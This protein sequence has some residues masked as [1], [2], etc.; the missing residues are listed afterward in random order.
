MV[1]KQRDIKRIKWAGKGGKQ[2]WMNN[3]KRWLGEEGRKKEVYGQK[4]QG[5]GEKGSG[6]YFHLSTALKAINTYKASALGPLG[7]CWSMC[8]FVCDGWLFTLMWFV[9][10]VLTVS[11][12]WLNL[13]LGEKLQT[14][15]YQC[16][17]CHCNIG[18][19][20]TSF[21]WQC[22]RTADT[23][24]VLERLQSRAPT[25]LLRGQR[26]SI[27]K[28]QYISKQFQM[29]Q[30]HAR[31]L[32]NICPCKNPSTWHFYEPTKYVNSCKPSCSY[33]LFYEG[34]MRMLP[35]V[36]VV[37]FRLDFWGYNYVRFPMQRSNSTTL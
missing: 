3:G 22:G 25:C 10:G 16:T 2:G 13:I 33:L 24:V 4:S 27:L 36:G 1:Q 31:V 28:D 20:V 26:G 9:I 19:T 37:S 12:P 15:G 6:I 18:A 14:S 5:K 8:V 29:I 30:Y 11:G 23:Q 32:S 34:I 7:Q 21:W 17:T 35:N